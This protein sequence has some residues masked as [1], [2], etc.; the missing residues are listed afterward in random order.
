MRKTF[1]TIGIFFVLLFFARVIE[2][3]YTKDPQLLLFQKSVNRQMEKSGF[4]DARI[5]TLHQEIA[6]ALPALKSLVKKD[7]SDGKYK[8]TFYIAGGKT[9]LFP[10]KLFLYN[11]YAVLFTDAEASQLE[12]IQLRFTKVSMNGEDFNTEVRIIENPTPNFDPQLE[13]LDRNEDM[14]LS[15]YEL[16]KTDDQHDEKETTTFSESPNEKF[17]LLKNLTFPDIS[18]FDKKMLIINAY[19]EYLAHTQAKTLDKEYSLKLGEAA[20]FR[21]IMTLD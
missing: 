17:E 13:K 6:N 9:H 5:D 7:E 20:F 4:A 8:I 16:Q 18:D 14:V 21:K 12:K 15:Y 11:V 2:A 10:N 19:K 1:I 3:Q